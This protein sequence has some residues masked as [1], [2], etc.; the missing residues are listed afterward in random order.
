MGFA[1]TYSEVINPDSI[2]VIGQRLM[3]VT[4][5]HGI[6]LWRLGSPLMTGG[7]CPHGEI[8]MAVY[9]LSRPWQVAQRGLGKWRTRKLLQFWIWQIK[10]CLTPQQKAS[11]VASLNDAVDRAF[12]GPI[13][14]ESGGGKGC[15][16]P[17]LQGLK[18]RLMSHLHQTREQALSYPIRE[19]IWDIDCF[20]EDQGR[21][22][23]VSERDHQAILAAKG[24]NG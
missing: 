13:M 22:D 1:K 9:V 4:I 5:G 12:A 6:L 24:A 7:D 11:A 23:W 8:A 21:V 18:V 14:W 16:A 20:A 19:A 10:H 15:S 2:H 17:Y 3:P